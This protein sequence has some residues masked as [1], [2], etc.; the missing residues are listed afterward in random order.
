MRMRPDLVHTHTHCAGN[1]AQCTVHSAMAVRPGALRAA[2]TAAEAEAPQSA[3]LGRGQHA[4]GGRG[5]AGGG[6]VAYQRVPDRQ[7][8]E[9]R[10]GGDP[11][12]AVGEVLE[13][14]ARIS[15]SRCPSDGSHVC[16]ALPRC[17]ACGCVQCR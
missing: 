16:L 3:E 14:R 9:G 17:A 2:D 8:E 7:D 13:D 6:T 11:S 1:S 15:L 10:A 12:Q 5:A 4:P